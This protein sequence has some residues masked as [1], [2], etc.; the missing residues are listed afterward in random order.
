MHVVGAM[1]KNVLKELKAQ[2]LTFYKTR[3]APASG[4]PTERAG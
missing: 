1:R 2:P 4:A 3:P